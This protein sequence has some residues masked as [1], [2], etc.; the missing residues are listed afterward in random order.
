MNITVDL[1]K[2]PDGKELN[3]DYSLSLYDEEGKMVVEGPVLSSDTK[4]YTFENIVSKNE[5][6]NYTVRIKTVGS[7]KQKMCTVNANFKTG[8]SAVVG[9]FSDWESLLTPT[10]D[11]ELDNSSTNSGTASSGSDNPSSSAVSASGEAHSG[12]STGASN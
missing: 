11:M 4:S 5:S 1:P 8:K 7:E 6:V 12:N 10:L 9:E 2:I 3:G